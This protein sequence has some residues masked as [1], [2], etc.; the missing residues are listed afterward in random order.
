MK[1]KNMDEEINPPDNLE[2]NTTGSKGEVFTPEEIEKNINLIKKDF[3]EAFEYSLIK[4]QEII[5]DKYKQFLT[6]FL[7]KTI[8]KFLIKGKIYK[9]FKDEWEFFIDIIRNY[10]NYQDIEDNIENIVE[11]NYNKFVKK[12]V[13]L[14][15]LN[16]EHPVYN[17]IMRILHSELRIRILHL[18]KVVFS[19]GN[20]YFELIINAFRDKKY[21]ENIMEDFYVNAGKII[22][23]IEENND[24][25]KIPLLEL[26]YVPKD[27]RVL[28]EIYEFAITYFNE[29]IK[30]IFEE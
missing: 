3:F 30:E 7:I 10:K 15:Y 16:K 25:I 12:E 27:I 13:G 24:L 22:D 26:P 11:N 20:S 17:E 8:Y 19:H 4:I 1:G 21:T 23:L 14:K 28:R 18:S 6:H 5:E 29:K 9:Y 2:H